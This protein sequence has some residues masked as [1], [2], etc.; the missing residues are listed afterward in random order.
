[1]AGQPKKLKKYSMPKGHL[2]GTARRRDEPIMYDELKGKWNIMITP[3][4]KQIITKAAKL[5]N[6]SASEFIERWAR[7]ELIK[8]EIE[9]PTKE[10]V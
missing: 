10:E 2:K 3:T 5:Q 4:A 9:I 7:T 6:F 8:L 1:M